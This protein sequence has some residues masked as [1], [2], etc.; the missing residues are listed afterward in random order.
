MLTKLVLLSL[1]LT[2]FCCQSFSLFGDSQQ[3]LL[4]SSLEQT[5]DA[6]EPPPA[7]T[8]AHACSENVSCECHHDDGGESSQEEPDEKIYDLLLKVL[9]VFD[10]QAQRDTDR[11]RR[12]LDLRQ[13]SGMITGPPNDDRNNDDGPTTKNL[14]L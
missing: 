8:I 2:K 1:V 9:Q 10:D 3:P 11:A 14:F 7:T 5:L 4:Q 13:F 6:E 12:L